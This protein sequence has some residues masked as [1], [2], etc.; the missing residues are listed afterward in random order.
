M[1][2]SQLF[3]NIISPPDDLKVLVSKTKRVLLNR[4]G[5]YK[6]FGSI[7]HI[8]VNTFFARKEDEARI[9]DRIKSKVGKIEPM[10]VAIRGFGYFPN[11]RTVFM[12]VDN[13]QEFSVLTKE[14]SFLKS[15]DSGARKFFSPCEPHLTLASRLKN[16]DFKQLKYEL[17]AKSFEYN[18]EADSLTVLK[19]DYERSRYGLFEEI[20]FGNKVN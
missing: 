6:Y 9:Y 11:T 4:Y 18:F 2:N 1:G 17:D 10:E 5:A 7:A 15:R 12:K 8:T 13:K 19:Y 20:P 3:L 14:L 16:D